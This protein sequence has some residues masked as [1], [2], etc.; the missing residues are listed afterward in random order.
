M[1]H[2]LIFKIAQ[3][4]DRYSIVRYESLHDQVVVRQMDTSMEIGMLT[5]KPIKDHESSFF[6]LII[7]F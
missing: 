6:F 4:T 3:R 2:I 5:H 1:D 7:F